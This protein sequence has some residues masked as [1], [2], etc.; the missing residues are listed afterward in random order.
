[1]TSQVIPNSGTVLLNVVSGKEFHAEFD[2]VMKLYG[3]DFNSTNLKS[4]L[5]ILKSHFLSSFEPV[6]L[7]S[8]RVLSQPRGVTIRS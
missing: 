1:M 8:I 7:S 5:K 6:R 2:D 4:Q 3:C